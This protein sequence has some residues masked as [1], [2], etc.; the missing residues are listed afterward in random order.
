MD[1]HAHVRS[2]PPEGVQTPFGAAKQGVMHAARIGSS[3][4]LKRVLRLLSMGGWHSTRDIVRNADVMAV[5]ACIS[6]LRANGIAV[7]ARLVRGYWYYRL[8]W[9]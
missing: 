2:L 7:A 5:S 4:R 1:P 3:A 6:E 9:A 8:G